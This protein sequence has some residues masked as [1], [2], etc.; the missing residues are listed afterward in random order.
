MVFV[1][2]GLVQAKWGTEYLPFSPP[3]SL[4]GLVDI[5]GLQYPEYRLFMIGVS[6]ALL[7]F[8]IV[9]LRQKVVQR[10]WPQLSIFSRLHIKSDS[11]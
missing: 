7:I 2:I 8:M 3:E 6:L 9:I 11:N 1:I 10:K 5:A 4:N